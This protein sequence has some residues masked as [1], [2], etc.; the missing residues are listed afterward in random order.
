MAADIM[1]G[2]QEVSV[3]M[4]EQKR[5]SHLLLVSHLLRRDDSRKIWLHSITFA[6]S[7][8][9]RVS[10]KLGEISTPFEAKLTKSVRRVEIDHPEPEVVHKP[11]VRPFFGPRVS[12][13]FEG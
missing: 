13:L 6:P 8:K 2:R 10:R 1:R 12:H 11:N 3:G 7:R 4:P 9:V 5:V